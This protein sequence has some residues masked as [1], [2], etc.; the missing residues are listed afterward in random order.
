MYSGTYPDAKAEIC[1][2]PLGHL[3]GRSRKFSHA[4]GKAYELSTDAGAASDQISSSSCSLSADWDHTGADATGEEVTLPFSVSEHTHP[5]S[6]C[7]RLAHPRL[8]GVATLPTLSSNASG[9]DRVVRIPARTTATLR[10]VGYR[11]VYRAFLSVSSIVPVIAW[12][13]TSIFSPTP[14]RRT[15]NDA[16]SCSLKLC[17]GMARRRHGV[18]A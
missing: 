7:G 15:Q 10:G 16:V 13:A 11:R 6:S 8:Q 2:P 5:R 9:L 3:R 12:T 4:R 17:H 1:T 18:S 14:T